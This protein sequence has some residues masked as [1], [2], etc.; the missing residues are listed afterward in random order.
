MPTLTKTLKARHP[1]RCAWCRE[2]IPAGTTYARSA[3]IGDG[4]AHTVKMHTE[5]RDAWVWACCCCYWLHAEDDF[6]PTCNYRDYQVRGRVSV[7][8]VEL[9][10]EQA[11]AW[12]DALQKWHYNGGPQPEARDY[13]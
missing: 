9:T 12:N 2:A 3:C 6:C 8:G 11:R 7:D 10:P 4:T 5:C 1:H 13:V